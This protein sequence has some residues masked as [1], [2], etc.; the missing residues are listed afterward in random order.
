MNGSIVMPTIAAARIR[1]PQRC[2]NCG[3]VALQPDG[4]RLECRRNP[5]VL[6]MLPQGIASAFPGVQPDQWCKTGWTT[7][8]ELASS[9][10]V[11]S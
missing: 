7:K 8:V 10:E 1:R 4:Q 3:C 2:E 6:V 9:V 11:A 5:P